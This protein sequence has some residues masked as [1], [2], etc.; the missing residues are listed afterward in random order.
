MLGVREKDVNVIDNGLDNSIVGDRNLDATIVFYGSDNRLVIGVNV[1]FH[2]ASIVFDGFGNEITIGDGSELW[3]DLSLSVS[4]TNGK[5]AIG[6]NCLFSNN[7][8]IRN[9]DGHA[10]LDLATG[11]RLNPSMDVVVG[12][13]VWVCENVHILKGARI[14][15]DSVVG[16]GSIVT[17]GVFPN[18]V[19]VAGNPARVV[20]TGIRW[21]E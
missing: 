21:Q 5:I 15:N 3:T 16:A 11:Q 10:I 7:V 13:R 4:G 6:R 14:G 19:V 17:R 20:K 18:N 2:A 1:K 8:R 12:D 9:G